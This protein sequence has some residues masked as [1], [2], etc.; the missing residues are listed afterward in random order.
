MIRDRYEPLSLFD[1]V[2]QLQLRIEPE[3]AEL[4]RLLDDG[5]LFPKVKADLARRWP[6]S[7]VTGRPS[8][9]VEVV[10]RLLVVKHLSQ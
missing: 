3:L 5:V 8:T 7:L 6:K 10:P 9:P 2:P 1:L 4:D